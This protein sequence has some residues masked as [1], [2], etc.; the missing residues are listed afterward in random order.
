MGVR[1]DG[2]VPAQDSE[3]NSAASA[4]VRAA[5]ARLGTVLRG[6]WQLRELL[7]TGAMASVYLGVHRNGSRVAVKVFD[8]MFP[9]QREFRPELLHRFMRE[10]TIAN[11]VA[12]PGVVKVLDEDIAPDGA[13]FIVM[14][15]IDGESL[16]DLLAREGPLEASRV[17][18]IGTQILDALAAA[19]EAGI[20]HRDVKPANVLVCR[21]GTT[22]L[23]DFGIARLR[24]GA[25]QFTREGAVMGTPAFMPPEQA[26][27]ARD[28]IEPRT[29]I[30]AV[31]ALLYELLTGKRAT[32]RSSDTSDATRLAIWRRA[33]PLRLHRPGLP[34]GLANV[35]ERALMLDVAERWPSAL[36][37]KEA[38]AHAIPAADAQKPAT[39]AAADTVAHET[40]PEDTLAQ[41]VP[42]PDAKGR[43]LKLVGA[44]F[45]RP[46]SSTPGSDAPLPLFTGLRLRP[47]SLRSPA[48]SSFPPQPAPPAESPADRPSNVVKWISIAGV[49]MFLALTAMLVWLSLDDRDER[50]HRTARTASSLPMPYASASAGALDASPPSR[51]ISPPP[52][53]MHNTSI[54]A[55]SPSDAPRADPPQQ[56][57]PPLPRANSPE[58]D[59]SKVPSRGDLPPPPRPLDGD[60][61]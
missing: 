39:V 14:E 28:A 32:D 46:I 50:P 1:R 8:P 2:I 38:L 44:G 22:K 51:E 21:D 13:P 27:G 30:W 26:L 23:V 10:G 56:S 5:K 43:T 49:G 11:R 55:S 16:A 36:A 35:V 61:F 58:G 47:T 3:G 41:E 52:S 9:L 17:V 40:P 53:Y 12:H 34:V 29:D 4:R 54:A 37:M 20:V 42:A 25:A 57:S 60:R 59:A 31:G 24:D 18:A 19:H 7:G 6:K 45:T 48:V 15:L 33:P